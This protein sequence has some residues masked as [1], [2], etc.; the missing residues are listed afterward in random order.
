M[1]SERY[2]CE[3]MMHAA[4]MCLYAG[5]SLEVKEGLREAIA[6]IHSE[7]ELQTA[8]TPK[9]V[10]VEDGTYHMLKERVGL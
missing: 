5:A 1:E 9:T 8:D 6:R 2:R 10:H 7:T 3:A 4:R